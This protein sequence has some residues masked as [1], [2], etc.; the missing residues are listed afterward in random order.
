M[1]LIVIFCVGLVAGWSAVLW[2]ASLAEEARPA[3][4]RWCR[5][6]AARLPV[7]SAVVPWAGHCSG[8]RARTSSGPWLAAVGTGCL[9]AVFAYLLEQGCQTVTEVRPAQALWQARLPFH[10]LLL[11]LLVTAVAADLIDYVIPDQIILP[12]TLAALLLSF[13][14]GDLQLIHIW[15]D[16]SDEM[17][18]VYGPW[19]PQWMK[20]HQ[21]LHGLAWSLCGAVSGASLVWAGRVAANRILGFPAIGFGDVTLMAMI[22]AFMGWQPVLCVLA[23]SP[24]AGIVL[25]LAVFV[26]TGRGFMAFGPCLAAGAVIVLCTWNA[27]WEQ[28]G[29]RIIFGHWPTIAGLILS[30]FSLYCLLLLGVRWFRSTPVS[31]LR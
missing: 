7:F 18:Q 20:D 29:L 23:V 19:L 12:G 2:A 22:G 11:F 17:V 31:R 10:L 9:F 4:I 16:W 13:A 5:G 1:W 30:A 28:Q 3:G 26:L 25:G 14:S 24:L 8:C 27:I 15:V 21:H 6:C